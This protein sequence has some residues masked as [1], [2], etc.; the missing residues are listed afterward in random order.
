MW[1]R[2][3]YGS[4]GNSITFRRVYSMV[5][6]TLEVKT[7][8]VK[9][10][11]SGFERVFRGEHRHRDARGHAC[12]AVTDGDDELVCQLAAGELSA[13]SRPFADGV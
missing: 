9:H 6:F 4:T 1:T 13:N 8:R 11:R 3:L 2:I 5:V 10:V 12:P 7:G